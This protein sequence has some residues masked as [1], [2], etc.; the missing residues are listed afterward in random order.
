MNNVILPKI[1]KSCQFYIELKKEPT[2]YQ[3]N[4]C[5]SKLM[6]HL[7]ELLDSHLTHFQIYIYIYI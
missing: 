1:L 7:P 4:K 3:F 5:H 6:G 2:C